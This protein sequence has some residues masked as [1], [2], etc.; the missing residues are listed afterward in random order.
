[1]GDT[2]AGTKQFTIDQFADDTAGLI[3]A[4]GFGQANV[5]GW[6]IGGDIALSLVVNHPYKVIKLVSYAG[7]CGGSQ[8]IDAP[9]YKDTLKSL[10][11]V[12]VP[13]KTLLAALWARS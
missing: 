1:M 9:K 12:D 4:L 13:A 7:D 10:Q 8:K 11:D 3:D 6:S 2:T 5:L